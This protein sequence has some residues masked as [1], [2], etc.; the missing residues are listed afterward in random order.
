VSK[1]VGKF[2]KDKDYNDDYN[3]AKKFLHSK[4]RRTEHPEVKK[5]LKHQEEEFYDDVSVS[6]DEKY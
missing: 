6:H 4:R 1:F 3:Y 5:Q 2:R